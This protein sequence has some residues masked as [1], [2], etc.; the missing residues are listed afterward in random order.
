MSILFLDNSGTARRGRRRLRSHC[1]L[2]GPPCPVE[3][4]PITDILSPSSPVLAESRYPV[5]RKRNVERAVSRLGACH[6]G[7]PGRKRRSM[8]DQHGCRQIAKHRL[9]GPATAMGGELSASPPVFTLSLIHISEPTRL[10][11]ISYA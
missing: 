3:R 10:G 5:S 9:R 7:R 6:L 2:E 1:Q 8:T 4:K 11:M